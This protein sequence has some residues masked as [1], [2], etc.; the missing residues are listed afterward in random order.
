MKKSL[1]VF[2]ITLLAVSILAYKVRVGDTIAIEVF[3]QPSLSRT[4]EV[5][6]DGTIAYPFAG[7]VRVEGK[8]VDEIKTIIEPYVKNILK[9]PIITVYVVKYAPMNIYIQGVLNR[10]FDISFTPNL[11]LSKL[12][13]YLSI[14][15][16]SPI[17]FG[18]ITVTRDGKSTKFDMTPF[19]F[20]GKVTNDIVLKENDTVY[21]PPLKYNMPIQVTGAYTLLT[22]YEPGMT[23]KYLLI[24]LG[25][26]DKTFAKIESSVLT[27]DGKSQIV[28]LEDVIAGKV[29][30]KLSTGASLYIPKR[31]ARFVYVVGFVPSS[32]VKTFSVEEDMNLALAL[33]KAGGISKENEKWIE[34]IR[35]TPPN[36]KVEDYQPDIL[37]NAFLVKLEIGSIVEVIKYSEFKVYLKGDIS[38]GVITFEP[39]EPKTLGHLFTKIGGIKTS[40]YK[41]IESV[42]VNNNPVNISKANEIVLNNK[43]VVEIKKYPEFKVYL[44][45]DLKT[46]IITFEPDEPKTLSGLLTKIGGIQTDQIKWIQSMKIN[47][48]E[49]DINNLDKYILSNNDVVSIKKYPEFYVYVQ[50]LA[51]LKGKVYFDPQEAKTLKLLIA[52]VG[53]PSEDVENEGKALINNNQEINLKDVIYNNKDYELSLGDIIQIVYEPFIVNTIGINAGVIQL[54]YKEPRTLSYLVKKLGIAQPESVDS[55]AL[56]RNGKETDYSVREIIYEKVNVPLEKY[57]TVVI[58]RAEINAVYLIGDVSA[59]VTFDYNEPITMQKILAKVGLSDLRRIDKI[60]LGDK[61]ID[62]KENKIIDKGS[63]LNVSLK[64]P[65]FVTAMGYIRT[66]GRVQFD[67]YET[68]NLKSLFAKLGGLIIGPELYYTSDKV[69]VMRDGKILAQYDAEKVYKG[70]EN[71]TLEDGDFVY[72]TTKEPN[73]VYVFGKG[74]QNGLVKF[75]ASEEFDLRTL[76][77]KIGGIKEG[78]SNKINIIV[79]N[80]IKTIKW[81]EST[82]IQLE[83]GSIL[84]FDVDRENYI[85]LITADGKPNMIYSDK[86]ITLYELLTKVGVDKNYR[87]LEL[88]SNTEKRTIELKDITQAR[89]YNVKPGDVVRILDTPENFAYVLGEVNKPGIIQLTENTTVLQAIIQAGYFAQKAAP[90]SV[91]LYKGGVNGKPVKVNLSAAISGG[92]LTDNPI[93]EPG[94]VIYVPS[95]IFKSAL[96]WVPII[97][98]LITFYN[99]VRGL[100]K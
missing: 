87:K 84:T 56:I 11:T 49:V 15:K 73:Y 51:N 13:S 6:N 25:V 81:T 71:A 66:T 40:E 23:L 37:S 30:Y 32:G 16:N 78:I 8:T 36:G 82:N 77:S 61:E 35:I 5:A 65:L 92:T 70:I 3:N 19:F 34:K 42:K 58:K 45:G 22:P 29:D 55:I 2:L 20:E 52:K 7:N 1:I 59:Y 27:V 91:W 83:N 53:L 95:D 28:N 26:I 88:L 64:K 75:N 76:I 98:N 31:Q 24:R 100:F 41:W 57:D 18:N 86:P 80:E 99:N 39:D 85:Y 74:V 54:S 50:G 93:V 44:T 4:V 68:P 12:F 79:N 67:Y 38:T 21:F 96:E 60:T 90:T 63:I 69:I 9:D 10:V 46:G 47:D 43:D 89:G 48:K 62:L 14:D 94:D 97:N 72:V 17:D 33:A